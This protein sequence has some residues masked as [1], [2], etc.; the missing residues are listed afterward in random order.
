MSICMGL[1]FDVRNIIIIKY[2]STVGLYF[3]YNPKINIH[4]LDDIDA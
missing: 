3:V 2:V 4:Y 1:W